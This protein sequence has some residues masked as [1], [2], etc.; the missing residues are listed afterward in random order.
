MALSASLK[1]H[2]LKFRF[3]AGTSRGVL[4]EKKVYYL[5]LKMDEH[6]GIGEC[7][8]IPGLSIDDQPGYAEKI[9]SICQEINSGI[10][11]RELDLADY[12]SISFGLETALLDVKARGSKIFFPGVFTEGKEGIPINGLVWMGSKEFMEQQIS[13]KIDNGFSC[14]KLKIGALDF[15]TEI[16][17]LSGIRKQF[18]VGEL[19]IRLDANGAFDIESAHEKLKRLSDF[20]IHSIE[21]PIKAGQWYEMAALCAS[22]PIHIALDEELIGINQDE[23]K[24]KMLL[25]IKPDYI[26][27]KPG[28]LGGIEKAQQW[29][30][31]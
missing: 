31:L 25:D 9:K 27:L 22:S 4:H 30:E 29:I 13:Q 19:E 24:E 14:I 10:D 7:S 18:S 2:T 1:E 5:L 8:V 21:Q 23:K 11:F 3:P 12:P 16:E 26:I 28:L 15:E 17:V 6:P 20:G